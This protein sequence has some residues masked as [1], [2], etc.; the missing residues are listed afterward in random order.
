MA[1]NLANDLRKDLKDEKLYLEFQP[2]IYSDNTIFGVEA[3]IRWEHNQFGFIQPPL[4]IAIAEESGLID[5]LGLWIFRSAVSKYNIFKEAGY[6]D[7]IISV[8]ITPSQLDNPALADEFIKIT[9]SLNV[10][11][12]KI[13]IEITEQ[14]A[15]GGNNRINAIKVLQEQG[16]R[17]AMDDFG[18]GHSSLMY[19]KELNLSTI[20]LDGSLI[21]EIQTNLSCRE[22][23][24]SI[25]FL[26]KSMN[27]HIIAECV[28]NE[29]QKNIL[30]ELNC[31][32]YQGFLYS[33]PLLLEDVLEFF[34]KK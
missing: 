30:K 29:T 22:I 5:E 32:C 25:V 19:L 17:V 14:A 23:I 27:I 31:Y 10:P 2:Q 18:M 15:L 21:S 12:N 16:F 20:K 34:N 33:K 8:N 1:R 24:S 26:C 6:G 11:F 3:L 28:E 4:L 9:K 7:I 13:E